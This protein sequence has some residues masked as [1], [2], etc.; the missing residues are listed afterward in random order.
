MV[1]VPAAAALAIAS[2]DEKWV[3]PSPDVLRCRAR[4]E[5]TP[6]EEDEDEEEDEEDEEDEEEEEEEMSFTPSLLVVVLLL[7]PLLAAPEVTETIFI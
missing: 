2:G 1:P 7:L 4:N 5:L 3:P 6:E